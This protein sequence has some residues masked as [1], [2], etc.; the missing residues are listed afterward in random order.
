MKKNEFVDVSDGIQ[1]FLP[2]KI[3]EDDLGNYG[4]VNKLKSSNLD[5]AV[6]NEC[7][8]GSK[9]IAGDIIAGVV[10]YSVNCENNFSKR[11]RVKSVFWAQN[12]F[13][14]SS[15]GI[16]VKMQKRRLGIWW[17]QDAQNLELGWD[18]I[19]YKVNYALNPEYL[20]LGISENILKTDFHDLGF[21]NT[22]LAIVKNLKIKNGSYPNSM[23]LHRELCNRNF[24]EWTIRNVRYYDNAFAD[25]V[26]YM[27]DGDYNRLLNQVYGQGT[28]AIIS[29]IKSKTHSSWD[30]DKTNV[31]ED[32]N[33]VPANKVLTL[34]NEEMEVT[35]ILL[36]QEG[37]MTAT[38]ENKI[39]KILDYSEGVFAF[40]YSNKGGESF[41]N[42]K[43]YKAPTTYSIESGSSIYGLAKY[44]NQWRGSRIVK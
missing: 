24:K 17:A 14:Y 10:G 22:I 12:W 1:L 16:K 44:D 39:E 19:K 15:V 25:L 5:Y 30:P 18:K 9:T 32:W 20:N 43:L 7:D 8:E 21:F 4:K 36:P 41:F 28:K 42:A 37:A 34:I 6:M 2:K 23:T 26:W 40:G 35:R 29:L 31:Y 3:F 33:N 11:K 27:K 13:F 38:N